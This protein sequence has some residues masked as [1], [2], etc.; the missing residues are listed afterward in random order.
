MAKSEAVGTLSVRLQG[1]L[2]VNLEHW[3]GWAMHVF[4]A[5]ALREGQR[6]S[7]YSY[8]IVY[9]SHHTM[10]PVP[11]AEA[12]ARRFGLQFLVWNA[13]QD[14]VTQQRA[15]LKPGWRDQDPSLRSEWKG[16][17]HHGVYSTRTSAFRIST[18]R[19]YYKREETFS[20]LAY[21]GDRERGLAWSRILPG[22]REL[23]CAH[24]CRCCYT[25][26]AE[27]STRVLFWHRSCAGRVQ[28]SGIISSP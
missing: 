27:T 20:S 15:S 13:G 1:P 25:R 8:D 16:F 5:A 4:C 19:G 17:L 21:L 24:I 11:N 7:R 3:L 2:F 28:F 26:L 23:C 10:T 9:A 18:T 6:E 12:H 14:N 22:S